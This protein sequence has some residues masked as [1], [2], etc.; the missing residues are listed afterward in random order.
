VFPGAVFAAQQCRTIDPEF[1]QVFTH[2]SLEL[3][4]YLRS[5]IE[6]NV[7]WA[8]IARKKPLQQAKRHHDDALTGNEQ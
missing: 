8:Q 5:R 6:A 3:Y 1:Q 2:K 4:F 7:K